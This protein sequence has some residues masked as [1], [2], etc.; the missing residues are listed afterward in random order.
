MMGDYLFPSAYN[1]RADI[2]HSAQGTYCFS[3]SYPVMNYFWTKT[4]SYVMDFKGMKVFGR[5]G[6]TIIKGMPIGGDNPADVFNLVDVCNLKI[7]NLSVTAIPGNGKQTYG[8]NAFSLIHCIENVEIQNCNVYNMP[9]FEKETYPDGGKAYTIQATEGT[10]QRNIR[11][12]NNTASNVSYGLD[13]T[14][15]GRKIDDLQEHIIFEGNTI[16]NA[17]VGCVIHQWDSPIGEHIP[18]VIVTDNFFLNCQLGVVC[19]TCKGAIVR[20]NTIVS[21]KEKKSR[22]YDGNFGIY[23]FGAYDVD[24]VAND[25]KMKKGTSLI[26]AVVYSYY[27]QYNGSVYNITIQ[28][29]RLNGNVTHYGIDI[30]SNVRN[31]PDELLYKNVRVINNSNKTKGGQFLSS[32]AKSFLK[33]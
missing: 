22:Y 10:L 33:Q 2:Y 21:R 18:P 4:H 32:L 28:D 24:I 5:G 14:K 1:L 23:L 29:N 31:S 6:K 19:Q 20:N 16:K 30:G 26:K 13:Y 15:T 3:G 17:I 12:Q 25:I 9:I 11:I 27:P 8:T 7:H